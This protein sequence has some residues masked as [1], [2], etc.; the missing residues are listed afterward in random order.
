MASYS[1]C[2]SKSRFSNSG[3]RSCNKFPN[4]STEVAILRCKK[5][6]KLPFERISV[7]E[8]GLSSRI[9][10]YSHNIKASVSP[11]TFRENFRF[12]FDLDPADICILKESPE[13]RYICFGLIIVVGTEGENWY[14][15]YEGMGATVVEESVCNLT[16]SFCVPEFD[17]VHICNMDAWST[18]YTGVS[19]TVEC[20]IIITFIGTAALRDCASTSVAYGTL[21]CISLCVY[22]KSP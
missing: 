7:N 18:S 20:P 13:V 21:L 3:R 10:A 22:G 16:R 6:L 5:H 1:C 17:C 4:C 11:R 19:N 15:V 9:S 2:F 12:G 14:G 8:V